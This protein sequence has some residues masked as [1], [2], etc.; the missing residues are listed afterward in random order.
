MK[1]TF[2]SLAMLLLAGP[3]F[4]ATGDWTEM[5]LLKNG[6]FVLHTPNY[7]YF[8]GKTATSWMDIINKKSTDCKFAHLEVKSERADFR[9]QLKCAQIV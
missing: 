4:A 3:V 1:K 7:V 9:Q 2:L 8:N 6:Q 5:F